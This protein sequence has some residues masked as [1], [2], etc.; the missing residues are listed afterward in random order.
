LGEA[1]DACGQSLKVGA[2]PE[3]S[4]ALSKILLKYFT[5]FH[6]SYLAI[7]CSE[8]NLSKCSCAFVNLSKHWIENIF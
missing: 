2:D 3:A 7:C 8:Q 5:K 6:F 4:L 1:F